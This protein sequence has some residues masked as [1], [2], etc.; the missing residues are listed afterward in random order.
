MGVPQNG[1]FIME[2]TIK[3]M[4]W[5]TPPISGNLHI[6]HDTKK[7]QGCLCGISSFLV[8]DSISA[9]AA[10]HQCEHIFQWIGLRN[11]YGT[12][13]FPIKLSSSKRGSWLVPVKRSLQPKSRKHGYAMICIPTRFH[14]NYAE[15]METM[16]TVI[17]RVMTS[18]GSPWD[19]QPAS[20][21][22]WLADVGSTGTLYTVDQLCN[23][24]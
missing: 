10:C 21:C 9:G 19:E 8:Q 16:E 23:D 2:H 14:L 15:W 12:M 3:W 20:P 4:I 24:L 1:W 13:V 5:G 18:H 6:N 11:I 7:T 22:L 17:R